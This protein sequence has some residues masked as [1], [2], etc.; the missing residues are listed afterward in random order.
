[1]RIHIK[2]PA[3]LVLVTALLLLTAFGNDSPQMVIK[4]ICN[5]SAIQSGDIMVL[6]NAASIQTEK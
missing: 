2:Y 5:I 4:I 1:M 6:E 3:H